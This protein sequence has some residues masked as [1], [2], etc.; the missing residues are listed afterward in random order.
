MA[1]TFHII[2]KALQQAITLNRSEAGEACRSLRQ[3]P[4]S[5]PEANYNLGIMAIGVG[6]PDGTLLFLQN[7]LEANPTYRYHWL[8]YAEA[9]L[10][11]GRVQDAELALELGMRHGLSG[12]AAEA[13]MARIADERR[14]SAAPPRHLRQRRGTNSRHP[15]P[16]GAKKAKHTE[17]EAS[18]L[19][20]Q[21]V[22][23]HQRGRLAEAERLY[24]QALSLDAGHADS[25]NMLGIIAHQRGYLEV[26]IEMIGKAI[27]LNE[28]VAEFHFNLGMLLSHQGRLEEAVVRYE[29]A[30]AMK[31]EYPEALYNLGNALVGLGRLGEAVAAYEHAIAVR[32]EFPEA[33]SSLGNALQGQGR[34]GEAI[35]S[36]EQALAIWPNFPEALSS[37]GN[38]LMDNG[39]FD[40]AAVCYQQALAIR[41]DNPEAPCRLG[42]ALCAQDKIEQ[43]MKAA[44]Y[45]LRIEEGPASRLLFCDCLKAAGPELYRSG[46]LELVYGLAV[47]A[48]TEAWVRPKDLACPCLSLALARNEALQRLMSRALEVWPGRFAAAVEP[49][50]WAALAGDPLLLCLLKATAIPQAECERLLACLR[51]AMLAAVEAAPAGEGDLVAC[52]SALAQHCFITEYVFALPPEENERAGRLR[53]EVA[54]ALAAEREVAPL[55]LMAVAAYFPLHTLPRAGTLLCGEWPAEV[56]EVLRQQIEEP[57]EEARLRDAIPRL[58]PI[59]EPLSAAVRA[60]YEQNPYPR[61]VREPASSEMS[62]LDACLHREFPLAPFDNQEQNGEMYI[63]VA[64]C[65]TGQHPIQTARRFPRSRIL[66]IDLSLSSL[67]YAARKS[68]EAGITNIEYAQADMMH[69]GDLGRSF[70]VIEAVGSLMCLESPLDGW[71]LLLSLL[72]PGGF[73]RIGLYSELARECVVAARGHIAAQGYQGSQAEDIRRCRQEIMA[74]GADGPLARLLSLGDFYTTSEC[75]DLLFHVQEA[76]HTIPQIKEN[77]MELGLTFIGFSLEP[78]VVRKYRSRFPEDYSR[79]SL[80][81]WDL[82]EHEHPEVFTGLYQFWVQKN[83]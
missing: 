42:S 46:Q 50:T 56:R 68:R 63:L 74:Q 77:L 1:D 29:H 41:P 2:E 17:S 30:L 53:D 36:Y 48:V 69:L 38:A 25:L 10:A 7:T 47:R 8:S 78:G 57:G 28:E 11:A 21:A 3:A 60:Q 76:R 31:P 6:E 58:T 19:F 83:R 43:A 5:R 34:L 54:A 24:R 55:A 75:R 9:L 81:F 12:A 66:A 33:L 23:H 62:S 39:S 4:P 18:R 67:A 64:G 65:G 15:E 49:E 72:R 59:E 20:G 51:S 32:P 14:T 70:D 73:M 37:L 44:L 80:D 79:T 82:F 40:G 22:A 16:A 13:L 52:F 35:V 27:S 26:A 45:A 61:W 71:K